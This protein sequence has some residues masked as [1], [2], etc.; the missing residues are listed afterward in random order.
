V[1]SETEH[2]QVQSETEHVPIQVQSKPM[3]TEAVQVQS[4]P[5][6]TKAV[7]I[8]QVPDAIFDVQVLHE[9][10]PA[11]GTCLGRPTTTKK[12]KSMAKIIGLEPPPSNSK[13]KKKKG[14]AKKK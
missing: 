13:T 5:V 10:I 12:T 4:E 9:T 2:V 7:F 3:Q 8:V 14:R 6:K 11:V 1:Q